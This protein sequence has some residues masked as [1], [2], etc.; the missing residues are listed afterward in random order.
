MSPQIKKA[1]GIIEEFSPHKLA[2]SLELSKVPDHLI[3]E[4]SSQVQRSLGQTVDT[5]VIHQKTREILENRGL[6]DL[7]FDYDLRRAV[8]RLGPS[9]YPF[10]KYVSKILAMKGFDT[11][12]NQII[13]GKCISHEIDVVA[14][15]GPSHYLIEC[16]FH[17]F[18]G[19]KSDVQV[20][21]YTYAR[22]LDI[23]EV[24][25]TDP[26]HQKEIYQAWLIT[27]TKATK[28]SIDYST[29]RGMKLLSW[30]YPVEG[31][32]KSLITETKLL[33]VTSITSLSDKQLDTLIS[34]DIITIV[35]LENQFQFQTLREIIPDD[36][37][38]L[39]K[40]QIKKI[41]SVSYQAKQSE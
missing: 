38:S 8:M 4:I 9:G 36:Q 40:N 1:S 12:P 30:T 17:S 32:L 22:F 5:H 18:P 10:E 25:E 34:R 27:N 28:D 2:K 33:P 14:H 20:A 35:D 13:R 37:Q 23:K 15:Q 39:I 16:K 26:L 6:Y 7:S 31:N 21:L 29:C 11:K 3:K 19:T 24:L 41:K